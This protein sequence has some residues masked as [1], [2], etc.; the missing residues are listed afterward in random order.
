MRRSDHGIH[1]AARWRWAS[2]KPRRPALRRQVERVYLI[3]TF[4]RSLLL[5]RCALDSSTW[6]AR[7]VLAV[8]STRAPPARSTRPIGSHLSTPPSDSERSMSLR[9]QAQLGCNGMTQRGHCVPSW[10]SRCLGLADQPPEL[11]TASRGEPPGT[12]WIGPN[13]NKLPANANTILY[14]V[15]AFESSTVVV[16]GPVVSTRPVRGSTVSTRPSRCPEE[17]APT[18]SRQEGERDDQG[19]GVFGPL[20]TAPWY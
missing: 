11:L 19:T 1:F 13:S 8:R 12:P 14:R 3:E 7:R 4:R 15:W 20:G 9:Q 17:L 10:R 6:A 5:S 18:G 2:T 16:S